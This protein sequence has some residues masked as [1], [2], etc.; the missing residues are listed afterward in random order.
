MVNKQVIAIISPV[1][2]KF[3][4]YKQVIVEKYIAVKILIITHVIQNNEFN[5]RHASVTM[6]GEIYIYELKIK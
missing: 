4:S 6:C 1:D 3:I 2:V 5:W